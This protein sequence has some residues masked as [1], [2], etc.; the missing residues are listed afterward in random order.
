MVPPGRQ[1]RSRSWWERRRAPRACLVLK[2]LLVAVFVS[3]GRG[4]VNEGALALQFVCLERC[5]LLR[6]LRICRV[7]PIIRCLDENGQL[8][9]WTG[10]SPAKDGLNGFL[11]LL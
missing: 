8:G 10:A 5:K 9:F 4:I 11:F 6:L 2:E 1:H 7:V 3:T